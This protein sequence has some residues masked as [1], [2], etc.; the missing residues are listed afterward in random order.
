MQEIEA[1]IINSFG[2]ILKADLTQPGKTSRV[3]KLVKIQ[4]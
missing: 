3:I 1:K 4:N 2:K